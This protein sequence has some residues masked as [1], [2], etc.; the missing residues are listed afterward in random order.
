MSHTVVRRSALVVHAE[1]LCVG[2][3][4]LSDNDGHHVAFPHPQEG[5]FQSL[6]GDLQSNRN[7]EI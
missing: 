5:A 3:A 2:E 7:E 6:R 4:V 1:A